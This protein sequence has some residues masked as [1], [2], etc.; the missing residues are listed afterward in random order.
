M[1]SSPCFNV[2]RQV[3]CTLLGLAGITA[4]T[5]MVAQDSLTHQ[6][7]IVHVL[8]RLGY[9]P[10]PGDLQRVAETGL[11]AYIE[12]QLNPEQIPDHAAE[13]K[14]RQFPSLGWSLAA[15][16]EDDR[17]AAGIAVRRRASAIQK[18]QGAEQVATQPMSLQNDLDSA[19]FTRR[20][21]HNPDVPSMLTRADRRLSDEQ[22]P[23]DSRIVRAVFSERQLQE[24]MVDFWFNH[25]NIR[26]GD[27][28]LIT[29]WT[30]QVI[31]PN[32]LGRFQD[33]LVATA[34]HPAM[35]IYLDNWLS[36]A[37][38]DVVQS[39][40][41][42]W[43]PDG[44]IR[45]VAVRRR[46]GF[47]D[48]T[49]GLNENY[50]RELMELHTLGVDGGYTQQDVQEVARAFTGWTLTGPRED[51]AFGFE[52]LIHVEGDKLVLGRTIKAGGMDEGM[53][54]LRMLAAHPSTARF[55]SFKLARRF[56]SD[57][58]P[59]AVVEAAAKTF[60]ETD[61]DIRSVL[62]TIFNS[63]EFFSPE[64]HQVKIKKPIDMVVSALRVVDAEIDVSRVAPGTA[65]GRVLT[66][67]GEPLGQHEAPDGYPEV[68]TAWISTSALYERMSF[69][70][71]LTSGQVPGITVDLARADEHFREM[72]Y[73]APTPPQIAQAR[74]LLA[75]RA[76]LGAGG[77]AASM[78]AAD[79]MGAA[80]MKG[81]TGAQPPASD[82]QIRAIATAIHLGSPL[83][84]KR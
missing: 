46:A 77:A 25:F 52:P 66:Q 63:P 9:G 78:M 15:L 72:H 36:S 53:A 40:L 45:E 47:F 39:R 54:I 74:S 79:D 6:Q 62:R 10:R 43:R 68:A 56:L 65:L 67:M 83:F 2:W 21:L 8:N 81:T 69:A 31:R 26:V 75:R 70:L 38:N 76:T 34:T 41:A 42:T 61:G 84:Q 33:L 11:A 29:H 71:A 30:E 4:P 27:P 20:A 14:L 5:V 22:A 19:L 32:A 57:D 37:P 80:T 60:L 59:D 48:R 50:G 49:K 58:P 16:M 82:A 1:R 18:A 51:G 24:V 23:F 28:Y 12:A 7:K 35:M 3:L 17:P 73:S 55:V 64:Y 44:E 13:A